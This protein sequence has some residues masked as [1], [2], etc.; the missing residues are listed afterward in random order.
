MSSRYSFSFQRSAKGA[1][2]G[3][4]TAVAVNTR[5]GSSVYRFSFK[6]LRVS[7]DVVD[8]GNAAVAAASTDAYEIA[9]G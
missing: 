7:G 4:N 8:N 2:G 3:D 5:D 9:S 6:I 1:S